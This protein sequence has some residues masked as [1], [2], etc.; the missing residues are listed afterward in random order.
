MNLTFKSKLGLVFLGGLLGTILRWIIVNYAKGDT[1]PEV[2]IFFVNPIACG[3]LG[4]VLTY[5]YTNDKLRILIVPGLCGALSVFSAFLM[6]NPGFFKALELA[7]MQFLIGFLGT[8][9]GIKLGEI[10]T[11]RRES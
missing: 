6:N 10:Y 2:W 4:F 9:L 11:K 1:S 7:L 5:L 3:I 8:V